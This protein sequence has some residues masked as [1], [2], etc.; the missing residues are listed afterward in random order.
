MPGCESSSTPSAPS[1]R[2]SYQQTKV[3]HAGTFSERSQFDSARNLRAPLPYR[4]WLSI[5]KVWNCSLL[6]KLSA[7]RHS[8][9]WR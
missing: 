3:T 9:V 8:S 5:L 7:C 1:Q 2:A 4:R 6:M